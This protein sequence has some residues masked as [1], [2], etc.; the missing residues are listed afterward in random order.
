[1]AAR[2]RVN[3]PK[4]AVV[5]GRLGEPPDL[6]DLPRKDLCGPSSCP[7]VMAILGLQFCCSK[8]RGID[9]AAFLCAGEAR[10]RSLDAAGHG[11]AH[12]STSTVGSV[13]RRSRCTRIAAAC[14]SS[15]MT[16]MRLS[17][18]RQGGLDV[19]D[20]ELGNRLGGAHG[21]L[22]R[23]LIRRTLHDAEPFRRP[24]ASVCTSAWRTS[25]ALP[26]TTTGNANGSC[27]AASAGSR[28]HDPGGDAPNAR[29]TPGLAS[30][31]SMSSR[32]STEPLSGRGVRR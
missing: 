27:S 15:M 26:F 31:I 21:V 5:A 22:A 29:N 17:P 13:R 20:V 28:D 18:F 32:A 24:R 10:P 19:P 6:A 3:R 1:M 2:F 11:S 30:A 8:R 23:Q 4:A 9:P 12:S 25:L 7:I 16:R 14:L